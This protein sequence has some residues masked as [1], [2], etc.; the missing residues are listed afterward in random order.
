[1]ADE[2]AGLRQAYNNH[3]EQR[4]QSGIADWKVEER[5]RFVSR[6]LAEGATSLLE[7]GAG[8]G[9]DSLFFRQRGLQVAC[10]DLSDEMV[11]L[12][13]AKGLEAHRMDFGQM[14]FA[15]E[16][17]DAVH[18]MN[19]LLHVPS[20]K[21]DGVLQEVSRVLR[22]GGLFFYGVYGGKRSEGIWVQDSYEP[23][24]YFTMFADDELVDIASRRFRV[25]D[26]HTVGMGE[27]QPH[28]QALLLRKTAEARTS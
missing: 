23:K 2:T 11:R 20:A 18:A 22:P 6:I 4:N 7:I 16:S 9:R 3:A 13:R 12:C 15:D 10:V 8:T 14:T 24:R 21:L 1:M 17:F 5:E 27:G 28:F 19:C 25:E 26:F